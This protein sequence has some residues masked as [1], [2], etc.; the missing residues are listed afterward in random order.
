[1][2]TALKGNNDK[3]S[4]QD[5]TG[6]FQYLFT[7]SSIFDLNPEERASATEFE[8]SASVIGHAYSYKGAT[9]KAAIAALLAYI[10]LVILR[11]GYSLWA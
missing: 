8:M 10:I 1:M 7:R 9:Q 3:G 4:Q 2:I 5:A 6:W 11:F